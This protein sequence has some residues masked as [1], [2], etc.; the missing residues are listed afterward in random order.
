MSP[1]RHQKK[2]NKSK[3]M[4]GVGGLGKRTT[5]VLTTSLSVPISIEEMPGGQKEPTF[6]L[7]CFLWILAWAGEIV[8]RVS[9]L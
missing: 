1:R 5:L 9:L 4:C 3:C 6:R 7:L 2:P 8:G